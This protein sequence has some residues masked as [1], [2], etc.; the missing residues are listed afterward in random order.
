MF[1]VDG[2]LNMAIEDYADVKSVAKFLDVTRE[3]RRSWPQEERPNRRGEEEKLW[4]RGQSCW[5]WGLSPKV[6]RKPFQGA[7]EDEI[8]LEFQSQAIQLIYGRVPSSKWDWYFLMQ[9]HR[10]PTRLLDWTEN[11]LIALFF[12][13]QDEINNQDAAVWV[14]DPWWL[15]KKLHLGLRGP[16]LPDYDISGS[17]LFELEQAFEDR[18][19]NRALPAPIEPPHVDRRVAAQSSRFLVFGSTR[20]LTR[21][22]IVRKRGSRLARIRISTSASNRIRRELDDCGINYST[23]FPDLE[24]L[25]LHILWRWKDF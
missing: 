4:F 5:E 18:V 15:S 14:L 21:T 13:V 11:S 10:V 25:A 23:I 17:W 1:C 3:I 19:V 8:R 22:R 24:G 6:Y 2:L 16:L 12:A 20:D 9:H 7:D